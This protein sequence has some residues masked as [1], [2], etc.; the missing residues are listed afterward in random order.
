MEF[1]LPI[2]AQKWNESLY[3]YVDDASKSLRLCYC[4]AL[5]FQN[6]TSPLNK[7]MDLNIYEQQINLSSSKNVAAGNSS[8]ICARF[9]VF[10]IESPRSI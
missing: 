1:T 7:T 10:F 2:W 4:S 8:F 5:L 6:I 3:G 9:F